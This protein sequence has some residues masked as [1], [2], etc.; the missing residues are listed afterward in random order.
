[1]EAQPFTS[2]GVAALMAELYAL[3]DEQL[4]E[5][6]NEIN[7]DFISWMETNFTLSAD[8]QSYLENMDIQFIQAAAANVGL[9]VKNRLTVTVT[10]DGSSGSGSLKLVQ[11]KPRLDTTYDTTN[12][13][14]ATGELDF[15][16]S[17]QP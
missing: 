15:I 8:Q 5:Q 3:T 1:M 16:I 2:A 14:A 9:A 11:Q 17:Y 6:V 12:G 13:F 10:F 7:S 4:A